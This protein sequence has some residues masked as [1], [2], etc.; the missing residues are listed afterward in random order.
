[1][2]YEEYTWLN[3]MSETS[4]KVSKRTKYTKARIA[5]ETSNKEEIK[6]AILDLFFMK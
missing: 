2:R 1:M 6:I 5:I 3:E 4:V